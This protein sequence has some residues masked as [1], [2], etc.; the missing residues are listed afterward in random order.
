M[1]VG[2]A[3]A[4]ISSTSNQASVVGRG[5]F[6][7]ASYTSLQMKKEVDL[8]ELCHTLLEKAPKVSPRVSSINIVN[9]MSKFLNYG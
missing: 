2:V 9:P 7:S 6:S 8:K 4:N 5:M 1:H 3:Q